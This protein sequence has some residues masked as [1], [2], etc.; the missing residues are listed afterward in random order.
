MIE[1]ALVR[2]TVIPEIIKLLSNYYQ[3]SDL[4]ALQRFY[5]SK[6]AV[7]YADDQTGLYGQSALYITGMYI[8]EKD[9][10]I[11]TARLHK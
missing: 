9:G 3:I 7:N 6:T 5:E 4:D 8:M 11:N 1:H 10:Q 2:S